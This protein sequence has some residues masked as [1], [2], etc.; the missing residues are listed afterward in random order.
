MECLCFNLK[1]IVLVNYIPMYVKELA[2]VP[3]L[4]DPESQ[5]MTPPRRL[6]ILWFLYLFKSVFRQYMYRTLLISDAIQ[7]CLDSNLQHHKVALQQNDAVLSD[8]EHA[9]FLPFIGEFLTLYL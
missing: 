6:Q 3:I 5:G 8:L 1:C 4:L 7:L 9:E 2:H